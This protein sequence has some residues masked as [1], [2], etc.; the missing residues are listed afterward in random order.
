[1]NKT[2]MLLLGLIVLLGGWCV[3]LESRY[4]ENEKK[5]MGLVVFATMSYA[6]RREFI[7]K[8]APELKAKE[9]KAFKYEYEVIPTTSPY[10]N[11]AKAS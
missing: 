6:E 5:L 4:G 1:M 8:Y 7:E 10:L 3:R 2:T 11:T 9:S